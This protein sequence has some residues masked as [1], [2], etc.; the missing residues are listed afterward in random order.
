MKV[1]GNRLICPKPWTKDP[2]SGNNYESYHYEGYIGK[3]NIYIL[4]SYYEIYSNGKKEHRRNSV[5][6][7][8]KSDSEIYMVADVY[9]DENLL[10]FASTKL[11]EN[12]SSAK[13]IKD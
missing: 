4:E 12:P 7:F 11:I 3:D 8:F 6:Y 9:I 5:H 1:E 13:F 2:H 10:V